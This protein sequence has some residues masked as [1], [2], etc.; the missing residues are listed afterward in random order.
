M[1]RSLWLY[2][3]LVLFL[4][5]FSSCIFVLSYSN[6]LVFYLIIIPAY[7]LRRDRMSV[8]LDGKGGEKEQE[9]DQDILC[10]EK[11]IFTKR[12]K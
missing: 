9:T 7:F 10:E 5:F 6:L 4:V 1:G 11:Y 2:Q 8:H 12:E 3:F